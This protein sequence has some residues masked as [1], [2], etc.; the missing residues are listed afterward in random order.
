MIGGPPEDLDLEN[1]NNAGT[2]IGV[3]H[4]LQRG[5]YGDVIDQHGGFRSRRRQHTG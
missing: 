1:D 2:P 3:I 4:D 5:I